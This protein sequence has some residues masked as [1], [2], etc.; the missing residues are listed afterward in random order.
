MAEAV[1]ALGLP[2]VSVRVCHQL[3]PELAEIISRSTAVVFVDAAVDVGEVGLKEIQANDSSEVMAHHT[4]P[5]S[6]LRLAKDVFGRCPRAW[7][8]AIPAEDL[9]FGDG[10]SPRAEAGYQAALAMV[11]AMVRRFQA[12]SPSN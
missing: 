9:G 11:E 5:R 1:E 2:G 4:D 3:T 10:L 6:L 7:T 12:E 8:V